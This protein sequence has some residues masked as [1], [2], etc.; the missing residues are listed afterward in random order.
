MLSFPL[1]WL[2]LSLSLVLVFYILYVATHTHIYL[3]FVTLTCRQPQQQQQP[4][5]PPSSRHNLR[6][7]SN[8]SRPL[9]GPFNTI[10]P[11]SSA[12]GGPS[13]WWHNRMPRGAIPPHPDRS[14]AA[15]EAQLRDVPHRHR[16]TLMPNTP[17]ARPV[18][19]CR[20]CSWYRVASHFAD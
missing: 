13:H 3:M 9:R 20:S 11:S 19:H 12:H 14:S 7:H 8:T 6:V 15:C 16:S 18:I 5:Q 17:V 1:D 4:D 10:Y 2:S